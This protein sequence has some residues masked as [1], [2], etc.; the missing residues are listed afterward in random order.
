MSDRPA[1]SRAEQRVALELAG[2]LERACGI[3]TPEHLLE[4]LLQKARAL[5]PEGSTLEAFAARVASDEPALCAFVEG[6][7]THETRFFR[8]PEHFELVAQLWVTQRLTDP[9]DKCVRAWSVACSSGE[10]PFSLAMFLLD[11]FPSAQ[12]WS[13]EVL[14]TD[15]SRQVLARAARATWPLSRSGEI[16]ADRL[17]RF[18]LRGQGAQA[19]L[20]RAKPEL[21]QVVTLQQV[22]LTDPHYAIGADFDLVFLRNVLIYFS[23]DTRAQVLRSVLAHLAPDGLL[24]TGPSEGVS[25]IVEPRLKPVAPHVFRFTG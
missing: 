25:Y 8:H 23:A 18:M 12:G 21:R 16:T 2:L 11:H 5:V 24:V 14:A 19:G 17:E 22:N 3:V 4:N 7:C 20:M 13:C 1:L 15:L 6:M 10:E 9:R